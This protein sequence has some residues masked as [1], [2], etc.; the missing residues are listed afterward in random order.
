MIHITKMAT[1][2]K[3][4]KL[5]EKNRAGKPRKLSSK[6]LEATK[7]LRTGKLDTEKNSTE[8]WREIE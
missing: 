6:T 4:G 8:K 1:K 5:Q 7:R 3:S 2:A